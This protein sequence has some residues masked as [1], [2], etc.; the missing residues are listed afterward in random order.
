MRWLLLCGLLSGCMTTLP[1]HVRFGLDQ[2]SSTTGTT[3]AGP[4]GE[5]SLTSSQSVIAGAILVTLVFG[6]PMTKRLVIFIRSL[7]RRTAE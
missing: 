1:G 2:E 5:V 7:F 3:V 4:W 6:I